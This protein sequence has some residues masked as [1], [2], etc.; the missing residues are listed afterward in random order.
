MRV[1][2]KTHDGEHD[3]RLTKLVCR[4]TTEVTVAT[5]GFCMYDHALRC[6]ASAEPPPDPLM[7][8]SGPSEDRVS[9]GLT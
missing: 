2:I 3:L 8:A 7:R 4:A 6:N 9:A 1:R 5:D